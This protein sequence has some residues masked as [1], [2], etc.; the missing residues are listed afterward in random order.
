MHPDFADTTPLPDNVHPIHGARRVKPIPFPDTPYTQAHH[1]AAAA[2]DSSVQQMLDHGA[3]TSQ[4]VIEAWKWG[5]H[6]GERNAW[7][8]AMTLY[9]WSGLLIGLAI[10]A[11]AVGCGLLTTG[12]L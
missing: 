12:R 6:E 1:D 8:D 7:R 2:L 3:R 4:L 5:H 11:A 9:L 10:G